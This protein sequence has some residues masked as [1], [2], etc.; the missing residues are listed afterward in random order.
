MGMWEGLYLGMKNIREREEREMDREEARRIREED[1]EDRRRALDQ[2]RIDAYRQVVL[3]TLLDRVKEA[4]AEQDSINGLVTLGFSRP[5][6]EALVATGAVPRLM[7]TLEA[8]DYA[9]SVIAAYDQQ[10]VS[11]LQDRAEDGDTRAA[12]LLNGV[13]SG[14]NLKNPSEATAAIIEAAFQ[15]T[16]FEDIQSMA[17]REDPDRLGRMAPLGL[18]FSTADVGTETTRRLRREITESI[19]PLF[20]PDAIRE[21]D[22]E[23]IINEASAPGLSLLIT[24]TLR[25]A[26]SDLK[27]PVA[28]RNLTESDVLAKYTT[29]FLD[30][31]DAQPTATPEDFIPYL[32]TLAEQGPQAFIETFQQNF[33]PRQTGSQVETTGDTTSLI[34]DRGRQAGG[35]RPPEV[36][37]PEV[38]PVT[39]FNPSV[40]DPE[41][42]Q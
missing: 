25:A 35:V 19:G 29:P 7:E 38:D 15:A 17:L 4:K 10:T 12:A 16:S 28:G 26:E 8:S 32:P 30:L 22:G 40:F 14:A 24:R 34:I 37:I 36:T 6:A 42:L 21:D 23:I 5:S 2:A 1:R 11:I 31:R 20:G 18:S 33:V 27:N 3:P 13:Y 9:P 41:N 39:G